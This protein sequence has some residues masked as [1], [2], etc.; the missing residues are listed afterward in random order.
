MKKLR[1]YLK[2]NWRGKVRWFNALMTVFCFINVWRYSTHESV[3]DENTVFAIVWGIIGAVY[4]YIT[5]FK[6]YGERVAESPDPRPTE[7]KLHEEFAG[8]TPE[9]LQ[10]VIDDELRSEETKAVARELLEKTQ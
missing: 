2:R 7:E 3:G 6:T 8:L 5:F 10:A 4:L 1:E 9:E